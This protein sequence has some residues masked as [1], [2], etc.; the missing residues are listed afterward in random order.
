[1]KVTEGW[2]EAAGT[3][4]KLTPGVYDLIVENSETSEKKE[5]KGV[6][7]EAGKT[8]TLDAQL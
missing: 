1:V 4:F 8:Q 7:V 3:A 6:T 5:F 2:I